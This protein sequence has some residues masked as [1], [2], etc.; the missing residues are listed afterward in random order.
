MA[1]DVLATGEEEWL[2]DRWCRPRVEECKLR[3]GFGG[4]LRLR[5]RL[6]P[7]PHRHRRLPV[8]HNTQNGG[9]DRVSHAVLLTRILF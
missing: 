3:L 6:C 2:L 8:H 4:H 7:R 9:W 5:L 1:K